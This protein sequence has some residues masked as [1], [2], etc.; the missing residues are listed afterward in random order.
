MD[1]VTGAKKVI[2]ATEHTAYGKSRI[3]KRCSLPITG[4]GVVNWIVTD[5]ALVENVEG[6]GLVLRERA[7][8]VEVKEI[9]EKTEG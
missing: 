4:K 8:G 2:I 1:L 6:A 3:V 9:I 5:L 7:P